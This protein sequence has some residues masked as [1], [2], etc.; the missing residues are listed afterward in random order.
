MKRILF[1]LLMF[2]SILCASA[3]RVHKNVAN[4]KKPDVAAETPGQKLFKSMLPSTAKV[5]FVDSVVVSKAGFLSRLPLNA[6]AG[7]VQVT[8]PKADFPN[9]MAAYQNEL[10]DR[11]I[12]A[13]GDS[14]RSALYTQ[15]MLGSTWSKPVLMAGL[16]T[17]SYKA[18]N[19]PFLAADGVTLFFSASGSESMGGRDI[20]MSSFDSDNAQW[21]KPQNYGPPF[22]STANDYLLAIDDLDTLG[23]L[24]TDR[25]QPEGKVCIYTFVPTETR[26]TFDDDDLDDEELKAYAEIRSIK[27]TWKFGNR[28]AA[29]QRL[30]AMTKRLNSNVKSSSTMRFVVDDN[31]VVTS[32][33]QFRYEESRQLYRQVAELQQ[34]IAE[35][36]SKLERARKAY[37]EGNHALAESIL[38]SE[39]DLE[40][41]RSD[42]LTLEKQIRK[43]EK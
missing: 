2:S 22:S 8:D 16:D 10:G 42:L 35:T 1:F 29:M 37:H 40:Q 18:Q 30:S 32:P 11:R 38:Q 13:H 3:Q 24:V 5:M 43:T 6:E 14:V 7:M 19:Y 33:S 36:Q 20:F 27:D 23:W 9:Q 34:M 12:V 26:M 21:Y 15:T 31:T 17:A 4:A 39:K 25:H 28:R 41:Q